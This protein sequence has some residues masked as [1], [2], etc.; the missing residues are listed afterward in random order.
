MADI[1]LLSEQ[2]TSYLGLSTND[3][4]PKYQSGFRRGHF[5]ETLLLRLLSDCYGAIDWGRVTIYLPY[6]TLVQP[7]TPSTTKFLSTASL[8]PLDSLAFL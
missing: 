7:S 1:I 6:L 3:L 2:I 8:S 5:T 4:L